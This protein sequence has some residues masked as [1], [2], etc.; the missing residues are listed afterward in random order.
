MYFDNWNCVVLDPTS[1]QLSYIPTNIPVRNYMYVHVHVCHRISVPIKMLIPAW[2]DNIMASFL[3]KRQRYSQQTVVTIM[4][5]A[6]DLHF[7]V[8]P[9]KQVQIKNKYQHALCPSST[10]HCT[11][12]MYSAG[13]LL[14]NT[15]C[16]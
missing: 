2:G 4:M 16:L 1:F 6:R 9:N 11:L 13:T 5:F 3:L 7:V 8:V 12:Y 10:L 14:S 15:M